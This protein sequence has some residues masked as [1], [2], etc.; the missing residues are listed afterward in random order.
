MSTN[1]LSLVGQ[2]A[3]Q[4]LV[5]RVKVLAQREREAIATLIAHLAVLDERQ[6]YL[7]EGCASMFTY[8][9]QVLHLS[10]YAAHS[11]IEAARAARKY[12]LILDMLGDGSVNLTTVGLLAPDLT[13]EN[14]ADLLIPGTC[15]AAAT[16]AVRAFFHP[17]APDPKPRARIDRSE[18]CRTWLPACKWCN[19]ARVRKP[20]ARQSVVFRARTSGARSTTPG[21][22]TGHRSAGAPALQS[23]V[24]GECGDA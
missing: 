7:A 15:G 16:P 19:K 23:A 6:L 8:C 4:D 13:T 5:A 24:H 2:L 1:V 21:A 18:G 22:Q 14:H 9:V 17:Q 12:P 11:R 3:D 10:E 20:W